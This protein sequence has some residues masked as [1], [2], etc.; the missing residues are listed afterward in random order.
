MQID[1][2]YAGTRERTRIDTVEDKSAMRQMDDCVTYCNTARDSI[3]IS[4]SIGFN[5]LYP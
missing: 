5:I 3:D 4:L 2:C 1:D